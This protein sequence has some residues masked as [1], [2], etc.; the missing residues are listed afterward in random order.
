MKYFN[1]QDIIYK[2]HLVP[3]MED[4]HE[5]DTMDPLTAYNLF[6]KSTSS[7]DGA[8]SELNYYLEEPVLP[9]V[10]SFDILAWW[11]TNG[12]KY[13]VLQCVAKDIFAVLIS[14]VTSESAF[15]TDGQHLSL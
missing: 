1:E 3:S 12:I 7:A 10:A 2:D 14:I 5:Q 13:P 8:K 4:V 6:I 11:K 15:S 9:R